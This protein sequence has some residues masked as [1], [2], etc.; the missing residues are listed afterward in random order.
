MTPLALAATLTTSV[1]GLAAYS[2][3]DAAG[4]GTAPAA[5][6]RDIGLA[7]GV[8]GLAGGLLG[9]RLQ[10]RVGE[11]ALLTLLGTVATATALTHLLRG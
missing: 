1:T 6:F 5:P 8:G 2:A 7:L 3:L 9:A 10:H 11:G 4:V